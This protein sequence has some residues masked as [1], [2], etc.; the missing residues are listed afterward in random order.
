M[1][2]IFTLPDEVIANLVRQRLVLE[3]IGL[4]ASLLEREQG[5]RWEKVF[6]VVSPHFPDGKW[7]DNTEWP[8]VMASLTP[9]DR[10]QLTEMLG[11]D[12]FESIATALGLHRG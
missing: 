11:E 8:G 6:T 4:P 7:P 10:A 1:K 5:E 3:Q 2:P 12:S 9:A